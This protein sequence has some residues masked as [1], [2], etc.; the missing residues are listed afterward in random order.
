MRAHPA[1]ELPAKPLRNGDECKNKQ[2]NGEQQNEPVAE[3]KALP[4]YVKV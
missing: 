4:Q 3:R 2:K 1:A